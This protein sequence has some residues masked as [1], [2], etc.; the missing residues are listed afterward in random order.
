MKL[1]MLFFNLIAIT[2]L[3]V[4]LVMEFVDLD[5]TKEELNELIQRKIEEE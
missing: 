1:F 2:I 5:K 4:F 3:Y